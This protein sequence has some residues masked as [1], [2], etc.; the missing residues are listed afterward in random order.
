[1]ET[2]LLKIACDGGDLKIITKEICGLFFYQFSSSEFFEMPNYFSMTFIELK[3]CWKYVKNRY[4]KWHQLYL[5]Q[6]SSQMAD[7]VKRDYIIADEKNEYTV[8]SWLK[9][10]IGYGLDF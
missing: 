7:L 4:P 5:V 6:I 2:L 3:D 1:M 8:D 10:L 9:H